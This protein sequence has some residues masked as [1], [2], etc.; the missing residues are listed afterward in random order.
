MVASCAQQRG[1][2]ECDMADIDG[3]KDISAAPYA[4]DLARPNFPT[5][6]DIHIEPR[7]L[8]K[9]RLPLYIALFSFLGLFA[10]IFVP[11]LISLLTGRPMTFNLDFGN[12]QAS[13]FI[14]VLALYF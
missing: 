13:P 1:E 6:H 10:L 12:Q 5:A 14:Y 7:I 3:G 2:W 11:P 4:A 8:Q 9:S